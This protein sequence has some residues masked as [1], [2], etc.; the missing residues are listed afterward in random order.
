VLAQQLQELT[1]GDA[2]HRMAVNKKQLGE[3]K[4]QKGD[5]EVGKVP[6]VILFHGLGSGKKG[7]LARCVTV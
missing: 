2:L 3:C 6:L 5:R 4:D 7:G 1:V